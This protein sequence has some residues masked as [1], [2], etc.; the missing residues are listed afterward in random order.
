MGDCPN[1]E[2]IKTHLRDMENHMEDLYSHV[3]HV[4]MKKNPFD[5]A[6]VKSST[7]RK[8]RPANLYCINTGMLIS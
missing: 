2:D 5:V 8:A 6:A 4:E 7:R 3:S 1:V